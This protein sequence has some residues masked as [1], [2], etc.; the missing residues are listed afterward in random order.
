M[1]A[2]L[3]VLLVAV[4]AA[5]G[6]LYSWMAS[7][8]LRA[9]EGIVWFASRSGQS[10]SARE[11]F[12]AL[13]DLIRPN[14]GLIYVLDGND[15]VLQASTAQ[16]KWPVC[17]ERMGW[18]VPAWGK[19][20]LTRDLT[21]NGHRFALVVPIM[22]APDRTA[23]ILVMLSG[24]REP[25]PATISALI[26]A[27]QIA[28][29]ALEHSMMLEALQAQA[30]KADHDLH[31][32][33]EFFLDL[34]HDL[35]NFL[36]IALGLLSLEVSPETATAAIR[37]IRE[38]S[39]LLEST[40]RQEDPE[41][42]IRELVD[43]RRIVEEQIQGI[44]LLCQY[45]EIRIL[46]DFPDSSAP[47]MAW[48]DPVLARRTIGN[49]LT[50]ACNHCAHGGQIQAEIFR[51]GGFVVL[52]VQNDV[53]PT[54]LASSG[55]GRRGLRAAARSARATGGDLD[56]RIDPER[57]Q[58]IATLRFPLPPEGMGEKT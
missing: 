50:N 41:R 14:P 32:Y 31:S 55:A 6:W 44:A 25:H 15:Y 5:G 53:A 17:W 3:L 7:A 29:V 38:A 9:L 12:V 43:V 20:Y 47:V 16:E 23:G 51:E 36:G 24:N 22:P 48:A 35:R 40:L 46:A 4:I 49:V 28:G 1:I 8:F 42:Q 19:A 37:N 34:V 39:D 21:G 58:A 45:R 56:F 11:V 57:G 52:R 30:R 54:A 18:P 27:G 33:R 2:G 13:L 26:A 10:R